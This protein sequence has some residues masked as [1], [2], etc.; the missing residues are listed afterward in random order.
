MQGGGFGWTAAALRRQGHVLLLPRATRCACR[1][2]LSSHARATCCTRG[3]RC[4]GPAPQ[5]A[6]P[7]CPPCP[8]Q[9][10]PFPEPKRAKWHW[11]C[12]LEEMAVRGHACVLHCY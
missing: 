8:P 6:A 11:D 5:H 4:A 10:P 2:W 1:G 3:A 12:L 9:V 7:A